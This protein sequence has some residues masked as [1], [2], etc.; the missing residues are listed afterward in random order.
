MFLYYTPPPLPN[1]VRTA[2]KQT[3]GVC[4]DLPRRS[5]SGRRRAHQSCQ[6]GQVYLCTQILNNRSGLLC[7]A[8]GADCEYWEYCEYCGFIWGADEQTP[9]GYSA[10]EPYHTAKS[11]PS[12]YTETHQSSFYK[13][14]KSY[15]SHASV[16]PRRQQ[17]AET[18]QSS[19]KHA[20]GV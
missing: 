2:K 6:T 12:G 7:P 13:S 16:T 20:Y 18:Y 19:M 3:L 4:R 1:H 8:G 10:P 17:T 14:Y 11:K 15:K 9:G 5:P